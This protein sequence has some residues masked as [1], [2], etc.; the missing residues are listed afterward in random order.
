MMKYLKKL[1]DL[2][3]LQRNESNHITP[4]KD[5]EDLEFILDDYLDKVGPAFNFSLIKFDYGSD[6]YLKLTF[7]KDD[8]SFDDPVIQNLRRYFSVEINEAAAI[9]NINNTQLFQKIRKLTGLRLN[10]ISWTP[11]NDPDITKIVNLSLK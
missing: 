4:S 5:I 7:L 6:I 11:S 3:I 10:Y 1:R 8:L 2:D 9:I